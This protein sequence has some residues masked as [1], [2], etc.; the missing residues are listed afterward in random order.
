MPTEEE[1]KKR[2]LQ[3]RLQEMTMHQNSSMYEQNHMQEAL[4]SIMSKILDKKGKERM[5]NL[6]LVRPEMAMQ[7]EL[8][9]AQ[10]YQSGQVRGI[11]TDDQ[12][13]MILKKIS[14]RRDIKIKR[15]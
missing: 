12:L 14:E 7:L 9:L 6:K 10:L 8:Y 3:Q 1:I 11:I 15:K 5:S 4:E 2:M 13:V